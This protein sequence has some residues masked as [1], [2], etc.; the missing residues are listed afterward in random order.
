MMAPYFCE[1]SRV[2]WRDVNMNYEKGI[3]PGP[4]RY[5]IEG[6]ETVGTGEWKTLLDMSENNEDFNIDY[7]S[8]Y[9]VLCREARIRIVGWPKGI[10]P[11]IVSFTLF[12][13]RA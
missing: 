6:R 5:I 7:R 4:Y 3:L 2:M 11:G 8:F 13:T 12:G 9:P 10:I 1:A